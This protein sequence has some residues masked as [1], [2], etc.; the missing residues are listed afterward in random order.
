MAIQEIRLKVGLDYSGKKVEVDLP[1]ISEICDGLV[2]AGCERGKPYKGVDYG[3]FEVIH[4]HSRLSL[5]DAAP[6]W[7]E[8]VHSYGLL[9][10]NIARSYGFS[11]DHQKPARELLELASVL[12]ILFL[13]GVNP[14]A[15]EVEAILKGWAGGSDVE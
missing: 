8:Y 11:W 2:F 4:V 6:E 1:V 12:K 10:S 13:E 15:I 3:G 7:K 14:E 5:F 9:A